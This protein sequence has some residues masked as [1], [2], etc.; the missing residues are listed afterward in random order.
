[1]LD[2]TDR[3]LPAPSDRSGAVI[4]YP[5]DRIGPVQAEY[6]DEAEG[7]GLQLRELL[8]TLWGQKF[9]IIGVFA[10]IFTAV[11]AWTLTRTPIYTASARLEVEAREV[12]VMQGTEVQQAQ[13]ADQ[14]HMATQTA[15]L[16]SRALAERVVELLEL[17]S[18]PEFVKPSSVYPSLED[19]PLEDRLEQ[20]TLQLMNNMT[21]REVAR[22]RVID[23]SYESPDPAMAAAVTNGLADEFI[24]SAL[25]R[26]FNATSYA[27]SFLEERLQATRASLEDAERRLASY[28][29][30]QRVLDLSGEGQGQGIPGGSL[31]GAALIS[32]SASL[33]QAENERIA[34]EQRW[35][36]AQNGDLPEGV[37]GNQALTAL[38]QARSELAAERAELLAQFREDYPAVR[39]LG[40]RIEGLDAEI[41][42]EE[43][44]AVRSLEAAYTATLSREQA[45]RARVGELEGDVQ[46]LRARSIDYNILTREVDTLRSQYDALLQRYREVSIA[47]GIGTS[48]VSIVDRAVAPSRPSEPSIPRNLALGAF[49]AL[50]AGVG[51]AMLRAFLDDTIKTPEH[52]KDKL[53][54]P[55]LGVVP[56]MK[57]GDRSVLAELA[58]PRSPLTEAMRS[59]ALNLRFATPAGVP[60]S[61]LITGAKP[62][63]GKTSTV[64]GLAMTFAADGKKVLI[65]DG[66]MRRPSFSFERGASIGLSGLLSGGGSLREAV[67]ASPTPNLYLLPVGVMPPNPAEL[68]ASGPFGQIISEA[69]EFFDC[70]IVDSPPILGFADAPVMASHCEASLIVFASR[71]VQRPLAERAVGRLAGVRANVVGAIL[72]KF[73]VS[74]AGYGYGYG[75]GYDY[76]QGYGYGRDKDR[77]SVQ[78]EVSARRRVSLFLRDDRDG[79]DDDDRNQS[80]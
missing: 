21:V 78:S 40:S 17:E 22:S 54:L 46:D 10:I 32:L 67:I 18:N 58:D 15:L 53:G 24:A 64:T 68:L 31:D 16:R 4:A 2:R 7:D 25:E 55:V 49:L 6:G 71:S 80:A 50:L 45:L 26:R 8:A 5:G 44:R 79:E 69:S 38:R 77:R 56:K 20:A 9:L 11:A 13:V 59:A 28:S 61:L 34:A 29:Q 51:L 39:Q 60:R 37:A 12:Q 74:T 52:I 75:Y 48:Q 14:T 72:T 62:S 1:M 70:V 19:M 36:A 42:A 73:D 35:R 57:F 41:A 27:R 30:E 33:T 47:S 3:A 76:A 66:D 65:I 63:E 43:Q 23:V